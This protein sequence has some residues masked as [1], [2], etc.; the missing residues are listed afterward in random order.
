M[1][2]AASPELDPGYLDSFSLSACLDLL[3]STS[4]LD[5][6]LGT[7][8]EF[9][10]EAI[11]LPCD[12]NQPIDQGRL[13][14]SRPSSR[15]ASPFANWGLE[16]I[17]E[18]NT[19]NGERSGATNVS[20]DRSIQ[21]VRPKA[22]EKNRLAQKL[23][24]ERT[25]QRQKQNEEQVKLL[26]DRVAKLEQEKDTCQARNLL[27]EKLLSLNKQLS[28]APTDVSREVLPS[29][30]L[31]HP[32]QGWDRSQLNPSLHLALGPMDALEIFSPESARGMNWDTFSRLWK[33]FVNGLA[34]VLMHLSEDSS[35]ETARTSLKPLVWEATGMMAYLAF[36]NPEMMQ[37][38]HQGEFAG[39][40][41]DLAW[42]QHILSTVCFS[43]QQKE[44][45]L[46]A[47]RD[48][49]IR[50]GEVLK[51]RASV[52]RDMKAVQDA[53]S[54]PPAT[55]AQPT[56]GYVL[57]SRLSQQ[58]RN[59]LDDTHVCICEFMAH[60]WKHV[61]TP[62]QA[63]KFMV[64]AYPRGPDMLTLVH[65]LAEEAGEPMPSPMLL[66]HPFRHLLVDMPLLGSPGLP[67]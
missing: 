50:M 32:R 43:D 33:N 13:P 30:Q 12:G 26:L 59:H 3:P 14:Q 17:I 23:F 48:Y 21:P 7:P 8:E 20:G 38:L 11:P 18:Y 54:K 25:K 64:T 5:W 22:K 63:A 44:Q 9:G 36:H 16:N 10:L 41:A 55:I 19:G 47:R 4:G 29:V 57:L 6:C 45:L 28:P 24:R 40:K 67:I 2:T 58:L 35:N 42:W 39:F 34:K 56:G 66:G 1:T 61:L 46:L 53:C 31:W 49:L 15:S 62:E 51:N 27:L 65:H 60:C 37:T 52:C